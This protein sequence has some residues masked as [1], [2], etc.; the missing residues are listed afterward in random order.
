MTK[1]QFSVFRHDAVHALIRLNKA[2][3]EQFFISKWRHWNYE[4]ESCSLAF[5]EDGIPRVFACIQVVGST[6]KKSGTW[7]WGWANQHLPAQS[8]EAMKKV[9]DFGEAEGLTELT[10]AST[11]DDE[12][13]G[14]AMTAIAA[15]VLGGKGAYRCPADNGFLYLVYMDVNFAPDRLE[16][17]KGRK[18]IECGAHGG[19]FATYVCEHLASDPEQEWFS[20]DPNEDNRWP[21]SWCSLCDRSFQEE[22][23]WNEKNEKKIKIQLLCHHCYENHRA[24]QRHPTT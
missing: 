14:W 8:T 7:L 5:S 16:S 10:N 9:R 21:D 3:D 2:C 15:K 24:R 23:E 4:L 11:A 20:R 18:R 13:L 19:A 1:E 22:G 6:S 12:H 17:A